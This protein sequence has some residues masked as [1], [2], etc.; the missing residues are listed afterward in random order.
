[1]QELCLSRPEILGIP[2]PASAHCDAM[3]ALSVRSHY[4]LRTKVARVSFVRN[5]G[6]DS[7]THARVFH[8][9]QHH[10]HRHHEGWTS[11]YRRAGQICFGIR[12]T[13]KSLL[14]MLQLLH[15][16]CAGLGISS[17]SLSPT[18][19]LTHTFDIRYEAEYVS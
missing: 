19:L 8:D 11:T 16:S 3:V 17:S 6:G 18:P 14:R 1:M 7:Q 10:H 13:K 4:N 12:K 15:R 5:G 2:S 9:A